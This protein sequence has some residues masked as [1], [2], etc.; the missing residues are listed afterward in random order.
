MSALPRLVDWLIPENLAKDD[1]DVR[2]RARLVIAFTFAVTLSALLFAV[3]DEYLG[4]PDLALPTLVAGV[5]SGVILVLFRVTRSITL[6]THLMPPVIF[7]IVAH[8]CVLSGGICSPVV[9]WFTTVPMVAML[10]VGYRSSVIW[11]IATLAMLVALLQ[12]GGPDS[13]VIRQLDSNRLAV[14]SFSVVMGIT[15]MVYSLT[16]IYEK[17]KDHALDTVLAANRAK[18]EF[19]TNMSH[20]LRTPLTAILGFAELMQD[21]DGDPSAADRANK[22]QTIRRNGQHLMELIN[23]I[24][25]LSKIE[26][27]KMEVEWLV[28]SPARI[29]NDVVS[30]LQVRADDKN[31]TLSVAFEGLF[32]AAV[33]TDP[34]RLRQILINLVGNALKFTAAG[35]VTVT[36]RLV[37]ADPMHAKLQFDV[38]DTGIGLTAEQ[39]VR[40]FEPFS[41]ADAS[42]S[43]N[44]GGSGLGLA[45]SRKLARMLGGDIS[46]SSTPGKGSVFRLEVSV[47]NAAALVPIDAGET[48]VCPVVREVREPAHVLAPFPAVVKQ[49]ED[50]AGGSQSDGRVEQKP[51]PM[52]A[53]PLDGLKILLAEDGPDNRQLVGFV[54]R[55]AGADVAF[56][57]NGRIAVDKAHAADRAGKSFDIILMDMQMPVLDGYAATRELRSAGYVLPIIALTANAMSDDR[58]KCVDAGCDDYATKPINRPELLSIVARHARAQLV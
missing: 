32:P 55:R 8:I 31:L 9:A 14:W 45:I 35:S 16:L 29:L 57:E 17:M 34:T 3:V 19:L 50:L 52:P 22:L 47:G 42:C 20:E 58:Q 37:D 11:L 5:L 24:L 15:L 54:L 48:F 28:A 27:G 56:A 41:Q 30:L 12:F 2:R 46:I 38:A 53:K 4:L 23:G 43:R 51:L 10:V 7:G 44:Y 26:A 25:D 39:I 36:A 1:A 18:S 6:V 13:S 21:D 49:P 33:R 40:L